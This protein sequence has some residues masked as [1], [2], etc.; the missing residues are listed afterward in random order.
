MGGQLVGPLAL[1]HRAEPATTRIAISSS[2][3]QTP[4]SRAR[5]GARRAQ[6]GQH[7][8]GD[9]DEPGVPD[10]TSVSWP[11]GVSMGSCFPAVMELLTMPS[12]RP[13]PGVVERLRAAGCVFAEDEARAAGRGGRDRRRAGS[14]GRGPGRRPAAGAAR[15][16]GRVLRAAGRGR[17]GRL[18]A[19]AAHRVPR[20]PRRRRAGARA[21][22]GRR[23]VLR[24][25]RRRRG[26]RLA[27]VPGAEVYAAE[28]DPAAVAC[29]RRNL[30]P[31]RVFEGDLYDALPPALRGPGRR[32]RLPTRRTCRPRRSR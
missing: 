10:A 23:P 6:H 4:S 31:D 21:D 32:A 29:A 14:A 25:R 19:P 15:R 13:D 8:G 27:A 9:G 30:P 7:E 5:P 11:S 17:A 1:Q 26:G 22:V 3:I 18:R 20:P 12:V 16:L 2:R 28:L 24:H